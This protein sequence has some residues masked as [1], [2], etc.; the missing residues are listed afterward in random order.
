LKKT[1]IRMK[2]TVGLLAI[3]CWLIATASFAQKIK[4]KTGIEVLKGNRFQGFARE[5]GWID[6]QSDRSR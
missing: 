5:T 2:K 1:D 3:G 6:Y 4:I